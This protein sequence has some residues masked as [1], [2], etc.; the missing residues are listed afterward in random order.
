MLGR[1]PVPD[2]RAG[3]A[4]PICDPIE[5]RVLHLRRAKHHSTAMKVEIE[6]P[7]L[8]GRDDVQQDPMA[9]APFDLQ[10]PCAGR[11]R[12]TWKAAFPLGSRRAVS[13]RADLPPVRAR[14]RFPAHLVV[15]GARL[16]GNGF[17]T[18]ERRVEPRQ[19]AGVNIQARR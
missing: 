14:R 19:V 13:R 2:A 12:R 4:G 11:L 5:H 7:R 15:G 3:E 18:K 8:L 10:G 9:I 6:A 17:G 1:Q 16:R